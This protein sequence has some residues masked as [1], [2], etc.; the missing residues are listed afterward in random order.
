MTF[1]EVF[2]SQYNSN[3]M[4]IVMFCTEIM[5]LFKKI[6]GIGTVHCEKLTLFDPKRPLFDLRNLNKGL[7]I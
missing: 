5:I 4:K 6:T 7:L 1:F 3:L 2:E